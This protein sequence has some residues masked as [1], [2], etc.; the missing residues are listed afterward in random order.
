MKRFLIIAGLVLSVSNFCMA[1][2]D[3]NWGTE[4]DFNLLKHSYAA[5]KDTGEKID[6]RTEVEVEKDEISIIKVKGTQKTV[7]RCTSDLNF[8]SYK[9]YKDD[10]LVMNIT[11]DKNKL[12]MSYIKDDNVCKKSEE[13]PRKDVVYSGA[14]L[15]LLFTKYPFKSQKIL[16][17]NMVSENYEHFG[18]IKM[19]VKEEGMSEITLNN[20]KYKT[21]QLQFSPTGMGSLFYHAFFW[22]SVTKPHY[23]VK[24]DM[25]RGEIVV[26]TPD[27]SQKQKEETKSEELTTSEPISD[28][29]RKIIKTAEHVLI[30]METAKIEKQM[31][32]KKA[33]GS[34]KAYRMILYKK[35]QD[36]IIEFLEP[37]IEK[38]RIVLVRDGIGYMFFPNSNKSMRVV[39]QSGLMGGGFSI[40]DFLNDLL[41]NFDI[42]WK[43]TTSNYYIYVLDKK[44]NA[45]QGY[46]R[47]TYMI[48]KD[49]KPIKKM[50]YALSGKLLK[51]LN[52]YNIKKIGK[53][54]IPSTWQMNSNIV[55]EETMLKII[56]I[57]KN[58]TYSS[59]MF[60]IQYVRSMMGK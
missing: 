2:V 13:L 32:I 38:G 47:I 48:S 21:Y 12:H 34:K 51:T 56:C 11:R 23:L 4:F 8:I 29:D 3:S 27:D 52:F 17:L 41:A 24:Q 1:E 5:I 26:I 15:P 37:K 59:D 60:T 36:V 31:V 19:A 58:V 18:I 22:Y 57:D 45:K 40:E 54:E 43:G 7:I 10:K 39:L 42:V 44:R 20:K 28:E 14:V 16:E 35:D 46:S 30:G 55:D 25:K 9:Q 6:V 49:G 33:D 53:V 50:F